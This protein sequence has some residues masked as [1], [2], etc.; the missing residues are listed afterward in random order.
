MASNS[1]GETVEKED[2]VADV[3]SNDASINSGTNDQKKAEQKSSG[4]GWR[5]LSLLLLVVLLVLVGA[6]GWY[7]FQLYQRVDSASQYDEQQAAQVATI[8]EQLMAEKIARG[9]KEA[10]FAAQITDTELALSA[11][12]K[13]IAKL[14]SLNR[15][16]WIYTELE[17]LVRL[18]NQ[19]LLTERRPQGALALLEAADKLLASLDDAR[20]L[21]VRGVLARDISALRSVAIVDRE[22]IYSRLGALTPAVLGLAA[23]PSE[24]L[25]EL[26]TA[27]TISAG[28]DSANKNL[29]NGGDKTAESITTE[30]IASTGTWYDQ[31]W[32]NA[33][34]AFSRFGRDHFHVRYRDMPV[35]PLIS[36]DQEQ[37]LRHDMAINIST[38]QQALLRDEQQIY[39]ASLTTIGHHLQRY[40][41][42]SH[43]VLAV[44]AEVE[45]LRKVNIKQDLPDISSSIEALRQLQ[46]SPSRGADVGGVQ[47]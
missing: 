16:Q 30:D 40:F 7:G 26:A 6:V 43:E 19:R 20:A 5:W 23:L 1:E 28:A 45:A 39:Q 42:G 31:I 41:Q 22:G 29:A 33:K 21:S 37:W 36:A 47:P 13:A 18:A 27:S 12:A 46:A 9:T 3:G 25:S 10:E 8:N 4:G 14:S 38:A 34:S 35:E 2:N 15:D 11:Q 24:N 32:L 44:M 17:Y